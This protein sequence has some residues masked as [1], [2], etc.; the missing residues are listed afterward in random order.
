M[1][2]MKDIRDELSKIKSNYIQENKKIKAE[3]RN[4]KEEV[5]LKSEKDCERIQKYLDGEKNV[6]LTMVESFFIKI[7]PKIFWVLAII[8]SVV[9]AII[10]A[11]SWIFITVIISIVVWC[12]LSRII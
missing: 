5:I 2:T 3:W 8:L 6:Q 11:F 4:A 10:G 9:W 12:I 7:F 1:T